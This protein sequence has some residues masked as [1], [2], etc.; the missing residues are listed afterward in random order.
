MFQ[1][2]SKFSGKEINLIISLEDEFYSQ[3]KSI[4]IVCT[5]STLSFCKKVDC[6]F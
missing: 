1:P 5:G 3:D 6:L 4:I 2:M